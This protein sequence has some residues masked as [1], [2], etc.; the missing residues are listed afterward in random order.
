MPPGGV[1]GVPKYFLV[2]ALRGGPEELIAL[3]VGVV[4]VEVQ[5]RRRYHK[6]AYRAG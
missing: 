1:W 6:S 5:V 3:L 2:G 4:G